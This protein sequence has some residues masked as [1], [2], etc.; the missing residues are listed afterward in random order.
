M[1]AFLTGSQKYG[2][3]SKK[4]DVDLVVYVPDN[5]DALALWREADNANDQE[6][7]EGEMYPEG[8]RSCRYGRLNLV[9]LSDFLVWLCWA[10]GT[11]LASQIFKLS[12]CVVNRASAVAMM[13][14]AGVRSSDEDPFQEVQPTLDEALELRRSTMNNI[15]CL[16]QDKVTEMLRRDTEASAQI[17]KDSIAELLNMDEEED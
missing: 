10:T 9:V 15:R 16:V 5:D 11:A 13:R 12:G 1:Y 6:Q 14:A 4:S 7:D 8:T 3:P 17:K 2:E